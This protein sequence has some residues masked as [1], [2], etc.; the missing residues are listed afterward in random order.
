MIEKIEMFT[1]EV[2]HQPN[3]KLVNFSNQNLYA[4]TLFYDINKCTLHRSIYKYGTYVK[5]G[6]IYE[7]KILA[8]AINDKLI[9]P[10]KYTGKCLIFE[11][12]LE[13]QLMLL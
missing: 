7:L 8:E 1:D 4:V 6:T 11:P 10:I 9:I 5:H 3:A 12:S 2:R 13:L